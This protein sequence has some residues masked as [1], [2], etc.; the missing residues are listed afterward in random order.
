MANPQETAL[1][2]ADLAVKGVQDTEEIKVNESL[3]KMIRSAA[4][5]ADWKLT[6]DVVENICHNMSHGVPIETCAACVC[7][8]PKTLNN[9][10]KKGQ[11]E[12]CNLTEEQL[13]SATNILDLLSPYGKLFLKQ[14]QAKGNLMATIMDALYDKMMEQH[15]EWLL[16]YMAE[17]LEPETFNLK[18]KTEVM[19]MG[20]NNIN[21]GTQNFVNIQFI[22]GLEG[23]PKEDAEF[24]MNSLQQLDTKYSEKHKDINAINVSSNIKEE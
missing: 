9:W 21:M 19:K 1:T 3:V 14:A 16:T 15:N 18:Y 23:R 20:Q 11:E 17:R 22:N 5:V 13:D 10:L 12:V 24:I 2:E 4:P 6:D 8:P 7:V